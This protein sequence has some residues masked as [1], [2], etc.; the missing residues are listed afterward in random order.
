MRRFYINQIWA[1]KK[2]VTI[3]EQMVLFIVLAMD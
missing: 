3:M 1:K 2:T